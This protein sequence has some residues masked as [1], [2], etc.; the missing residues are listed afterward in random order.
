[1][2]DDLDR[3][4]DLSETYRAAALEAHRNRPASHRVKPTGY[5]HNPE[6]GDDFDPAPDGSQSAK[7]FCG[8]K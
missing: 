4:S 6:C 5:C 2:A 8:P 1:M 3:A 7:L